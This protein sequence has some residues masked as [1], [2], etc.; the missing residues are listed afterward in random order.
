MLIKKVVVILCIFLLLFPSSLSLA[1]DNQNEFSHS[2]IIGLNEEVVEDDF[3]EKKLKDKKTKKIKTK[4]NNLLVTDLNLTEYAEIVFEDEVLFVEEN[5]SVQMASINKANKKEIHESEQM[6]P[7]G[8]EAIGA[9]IA[10]E[11]GK[12][13]KN[14][15]IAVLDTGISE[16]PDL[17]IKDGISFVE[18]TDYQDEN[19]HGTHVAGTIAALNNEFGVV[20]IAPASN[21]YAV[22]VLDHEGNGSYA[23][24]IEGIQWAIDNKMDIISM[25]FGGE[26]YSQALHK[27][28]Q[29]ATDAGI[30]V[31]AAAGNLGLG[32]ET[33]IFPAGFSES[34]SVGAV[35][36]NLERAEYSSTGSEL[37]LIAP[38]TSILST[39]N[40]N[41]YGEMSGTSMAVPHVTGSAAILWAR[42]KKLTSEDVKNQLFAS[43]VSLGDIT[44][45]G[46]GL[47]TIQEGFQDVQESNEIDEEIIQ[48][49]EEPLSDIEEE[50]S[51]SEVSVFDQIS[52]AT[53]KLTLDDMIR[54]NISGAKYTTV[55]LKSD[56]SVVAVGR[57]Y[58]QLAVSDWTD[59]VEV[60]AGLYHTVG[61]KSDGSVV[62]VGSDNYGQLAVSDWT[63]IVEVAAGSYHSV[64]LKSDGSV[65]AI[66]RNDNGQLGVEGWTGIVEVATG[67]YHTVGLKNDG[68]VVAVGS[69]E[70]DQLKVESWTDIVKVAAGDYHTIGLKSDGSIVAVG[71]DD[72]NQLGVEEWT[73]IVDV[74]AGLYH[75]VAL[76]KDGSVA[77]VGRNNYDQIEVEGWRDIVAVAA[78]TYH[79]IGLKSDG[80]VVAVGRDY[81]G[82]VLG[83]SSWTD[84]KTPSGSVV[85]NSPLSLER[86]KS[87][88]I[89]AKSHT[90]GLKSDGN[91]VVVGRDTYGQLQADDWTDIVEVTTGSNHT[92]GLKSDGSVVAVGRDNYGQLQVDDWTYIVEVAAGGYHT[93]GL[94]SDGSVVAVGRDTS[95]ELGVENWTDVVEVAAGYYHTVG[96]KSDGSVVA[97]GSNEYGQIGVEGWTDIVAVSAGLYHTIGL[98]SDG[99]VVAVGQND[100]GQ[101]GIEGWSDIVQVSG[102]YYHTVGLKS[103]GSV[104][105]VGR[106][107]DGQLGV[108]FWTDIVEVAAGS[109]HTIGLKSD[110]SV[111]A[112]GSND[113]G[114]L[115]VEDWTDINIPSINGVDSTPNTPPEIIYSSISSS[116]GE[117]FAGVGSQVYLTIKLNEKIIEDPYISIMGKKADLFYYLN[118]VVASVTVTEEDPVGDIEFSI[119]GLED[120]SGNIA[121]PINSTI[122]M[123][124]TKIT[125]V[126]DTDL[127]LMT[128]PLGYNEDLILEKA[129][130]VLIPLLEER[131]I[132]LDLS[133]DTLGGYVQNPVSVSTTI[134]NDYYTTSGDEGTYGVSIG[135]KAIPAINTIILD[136]MD[137][138]AKATGFTLSTN[139]LTMEVKAI[140]NNGNII[141]LYKDIVCDVNNDNPQSQYSNYMCSD[142]SYDSSA[143]GRK[144]YSNWGD[145]KTYLNPDKLHL[146]SIGFIAE[147]F[148]SRELINQETENYISDEY[149]YQYIFDQE[150]IS[151]KDS[152][153]HNLSV[154]VITDSTE[155]YYIK[156]TGEHSSGRAISGRA[157]FTLVPEGNLIY[158]PE[159]GDSSHV[160][161]PSYTYSID[162]LS[163]RVN[164]QDS[165]GDEII[166]NMDIYE[167]G[168]GLIDQVISYSSIGDDLTVDTVS[169]YIRGDFCLDN[170]LNNTDCD[171]K[172]RLYNTETGIRMEDDD[173]IYKGTPD[174]EYLDYEMNLNN[175]EGSFYGL[176]LNNNVDTSFIMEG[177]DSANFD[178]IGLG[179]EDNKSSIQSL[180]EYNNGNGKYID[181]SDI[182]TAMRNLADYIIERHYGIN[183]PMNL[184]AMTS[185]SKVDLTWDVVETA[186][187]Y[188]VKRSS[189]LEGPYVTIAEN[190]VDPYFSDTTVVNGNSY[191]YV[192]SSISHIGESPNSNS[193]YVKLNNLPN[194]NITSH[195]DGQQLNEN[196]ITFHWDFSDID[197][198]KQIGYQVIGSQDN[199]ETWSYFSDIISSD[200]TT[201]TTPQLAGGEWDFGI[202]VYDGTN[203]SGWSY[204]NDLV[205]P[206]SYEPNDDATTAY[207]IAYYSNYT[208]TISSENDSDF[209]KYIP[210]QTGVD[211]I[212]F[213]SPETA[214]YSLYVYDAEMNLKGI[215]A[216]ELYYLVESG[217]T[218]YIKVFSED[219]SFSE[220]SYSFTVSPLK[221]NFQT[222][223]QYDENGNLIN[224]QTTIEH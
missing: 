96:L 195:F 107:D 5:A 173:A 136:R 209:Y 174:V 101:L 59:I 18:G 21:I 214:K 135:F 20:G 13:G 117:S 68:S 26:L 133:V 148:D 182:D 171:D 178:F 164:A 33:L 111:V 106:N 98:K 151:Y 80:S 153:Q 204:V 92:V 43:A 220:E 46:H 15:N 87:N 103:D 132:R 30:L 55:G 170:H 199:W 2:Y 94:K 12:D 76:K 44:E 208:S 185:D 47:V 70:Y 112:V 110:G 187:N 125:R 155:Y 130:D 97:V 16:H 191:Y 71:R 176:F 194:L 7:W 29:E 78:G 6:M 36:E 1:N 203:W 181:N 156:D 113:Y 17:K 179:N 190:L 165:N 79:T 56:G 35:N 193:V 162:G 58:G 63:G 158:Q 217:Q 51:E 152:I 139:N 147:A 34:I 10:L 72:Y 108:F 4:K 74:S 196:I 210:T 161:N 150:D 205:L 192:V 11:N 23:Q 37:D 102:G 186:E 66:G 85:D 99:K 143:L 119:Q 57:D 202:Q 27:A 19:G 126:L 159:I 144:L 48:V 118:N 114:Q 50:N 134:T 9:N 157:K 200:D 198:E 62:A 28:I 104:V 81:D 222:Q 154:D 45:Y 24:V 189:S 131:D 109:Y 22:K 115:G 215:L 123:D 149:I 183:Q 128:E 177:M 88:N 137:L 86:S 211:T 8:L 100:S 120:F 180:I 124:G 207:P 218:Y 39:L 75:T 95:G 163:L 40:D 41:R 140:D 53:V 168:E 90:V 223:Y 172:T 169:P 64:G 121:E 52:I 77:A 42:D 175:A 146:Y 49:E 206:I 65:V 82:Q 221:I 201:H 14:I 219:G 138:T 213:Q 32:D 3:I 84:I 142:A 216:S 91:V 184:Q 141:T 212:T 160:L 166:S 60:A 61:L 25:S 73:E 69:D 93:I 167:R 38:G 224:K 54:S 122:A 116:D 197:T 129:Q 188:I 83:V 67:L 145:M 105:S 127:I 89:S 31:I